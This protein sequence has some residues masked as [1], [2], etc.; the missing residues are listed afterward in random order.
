MSV[1]IHIVWVVL[2]WSLAGF[3]AGVI[4]GYAQR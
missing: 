1:T 4:F 3:A 2:P